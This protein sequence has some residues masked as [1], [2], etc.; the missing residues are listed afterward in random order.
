MGTEKDV[1]VRLRRATSA[2]A[3]SL[4]FLRAR[5]D[6]VSRFFSRAK[7]EITE[8]D[9]LAWYRRAL[10]DPERKMFVVE[11]DGSPVGYLRV[12]GPK[13]EVS[14]ALLP[15][16]RGRGIGPKALELACEHF[17]GAGLTAVISSDNAS[18]QSSFRKAGFILVDDDGKWQH[19][20]K[21]CED[22]HGRQQE[23]DGGRR[24]LRL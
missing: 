1:H 9:H 23:A 20:E 8:E 15:E 14:V 10:G 5:N 19:W 3:D 24:G 6:P 17:R 7:E 12:E 11:F 16:F 21:A 22:P 18:S 4:L 13:H 2:Q